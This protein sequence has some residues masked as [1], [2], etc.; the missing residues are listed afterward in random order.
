MKD[1]IQVNSVAVEIKKPPKLTKKEAIV[2]VPTVLLV[3]VKMV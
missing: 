3:A 2:P 1:V